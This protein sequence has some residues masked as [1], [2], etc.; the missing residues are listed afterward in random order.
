LAITSK[1]SYSTVFHRCLYL[2]LQCVQ[3]VIFPLKLKVDLWR[4]KWVWT[5]YPSSDWKSVYRIA[6]PLHRIKKRINGNLL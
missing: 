6:Q 4:T 3:T 1:V 5:G 2:I